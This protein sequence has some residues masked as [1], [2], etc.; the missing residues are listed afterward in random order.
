MA[1]LVTSDV[2]A[3]TLKC[4]ITAYNNSLRCEFEQG[5]VH[6]QD[7]VFV[8]NEELY[9]NLPQKTISIMRYAAL[10]NRR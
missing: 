1:A 8:R 6:H 4:Y 2:A 5:E 7:I 9:N 10:A 3:Y